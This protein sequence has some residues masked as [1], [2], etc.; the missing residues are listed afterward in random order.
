M[1]LLGFGLLVTLRLC[2]GSAIAPHDRADAT[3]ASAAQLIQARRAVI[4]EQRRAI[5]N[6]T[7]A[8]HN[9]IRPRV[10]TIAARIASA[11]RNSGS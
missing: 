1:P 4:L 8:K 5:I 2:S 9:E 11:N 6:A 7:Q 10:A 3:R